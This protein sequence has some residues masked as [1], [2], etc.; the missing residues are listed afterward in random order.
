MKAEAASA[1]LP[2]R[3]RSG[4]SPA[5]GRHGRRSPR[6]QLPKLPPQET[7]GGYKQA[8]KEQTGKQE[9]N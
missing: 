3:R 1:R 6:G 5:P 2:E 7:G 4:N 8:P 9:N